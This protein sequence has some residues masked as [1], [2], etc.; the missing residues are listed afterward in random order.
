MEAFDLDEALNKAG[1]DPY[2]DYELIEPDG[3]EPDEFKRRWI[4][5]AITDDILYGE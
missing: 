2:E 5:S 3:L 4:F 1:I